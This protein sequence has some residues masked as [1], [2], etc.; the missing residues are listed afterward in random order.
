M[1]L[2]GTFSNTWKGYTYEVSWSATQNTSGNYST[3]TCTHKLIC[4]PTWSLDIYGRTIT[5][6]INS[7]NKTVSTSSINTGGGVTITL[8]TTTHTVNHSSNGAGSF[9]LSST[10]PIQATISGSY[11]SSISVS[12]SATLNTIPRAS[13][14]TIPEFTMGTAG[15][16]NI[17]KASTDFTHTITYSFGSKSGTIANK[18]SGASVNWTPSVNE[19]AGQL[20]NST[21]GYGTLTLITYSGTTEVG[22][23]SYV[24]YCNVPSSVAPTVGTITLTPAAINGNNILVQSKNKLT[25][26]VTGSSAG[27]GSSIKSYTFDGPGISTTTTSSSVSINSVS[28]SG[29]LTYTIKVTDSRGRVTSKTATITCYGYAAP[30]FN[31]FEINRDSSNNI[32]CT[33]NVSYSVVNNTNKI[34]VKFSYK[35]ASGSWTDVTTTLPDSSKTNYT[36]LSNA[37]DEVYNVRATVTDSYGASVTSSTQTVFGSARIMNIPQ[38]GNGVSFGR[39]STVASADAAGKFE[40]GWDATFDKNI[41]TSGDISASGDIAASGNI[42]ASGNINGVVIS[43]NTYINGGAETVSSHEWVANSPSFIGTYTID[44]A[45][46]NVISVRHRN[47]EADG[48]SYGMELRSNLINDDSLSWRQQTNATW[49]NW[50]TLL[51]TGNTADFVIE[52][53]ASGEWTIRKWNNGTCECWRKITGTITS[54]GTWNN[55]KTFSGSADWPSNFFIENPNVQYQVYIGAGYAFPARGVLSTTTKFIWNAL[56]SD[57]DPNIGYTVDVYAVGRWK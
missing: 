5:C 30:S 4:G 49:K 37:G 27:T 11:Q 19:L 33:Y 55:M 3:I 8:G 35:K 9:S 43:K 6:T 24:F 38:G 52:Q 41:T 34:T 29:T 51:D 36:V 2:E 15:T 53:G 17:N 42:T 18:T 31:T 44:N 32:K 26:N 20:P 45:W 47:G 12:G 28:N 22:R 16:I 21:R 56:G 13:S 14:M 46:Y 7:V 48:P 50:K 57:G 40:V 23:N 39:K 54:N 1:A 25:I 10:F